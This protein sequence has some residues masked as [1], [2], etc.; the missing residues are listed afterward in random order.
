MKFS[1]MSKG[2]YKPRSNYGVVIGDTAEKIKLEGKI[3]SLENISNAHEDAKKE[4]EVLNAEIKYLKELTSGQQN[5]IQEISKS[6][7]S[8]VQ[9]L[10]EYARLQERFKQ[11]NLDF[12]ELENTHNKIVMERDALDI[13][14]SEV[15]QSGKLYEAQVDRLGT[16]LD[17]LQDLNAKLLSAKASMED[18]LE[19]LDLNYKKM[20]KVFDRQ[21]VELVETGEEKT[22]LQIKYNAIEREYLSSSARNTEDEQTI[23]TLT[24]E[25][26]KTDKVL[27]KY[28]DDNTGL[29]SEV[30]LKNSRL[31]TLTKEYNDL[32][33]DTGL[34]Y[35]QLLKLK[36]KS[37]QPQ[38]TSIS[39][40]ER[41]E[42]FKLPRNFEA[43]NSPLGSG[44]PTLLKV[45]AS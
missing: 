6:F 38:Y 12:S 21:A 35:K 22:G 28:M 10:E 16:E 20:K 30:L 42:N 17:G 7:S 40:I 1:E 19:E 43:P 44:K 25:G 32:R 23:K 45:R 39:S 31:N 3:K 11:A 4:I 14:V 27:S 15:E 18:D 34:L 29:S 2:S 13:K 26:K 5:S 9:E 37:T 24:T 41:N 36:L 8:N 33:E